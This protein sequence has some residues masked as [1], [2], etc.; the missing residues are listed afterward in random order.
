M[1]SASTGWALA[2]TNVGNGLGMLVRTTDGGGHWSS[3]GPPPSLA[4]T[5]GGADAPDGMKAWLLVAPSGYSTASHEQSVV[6]STNDGGTHWSS[7]PMFWVDGRGSGIQFLDAAHGWVFATPSAGGAIGAGDTTLYRTVD[8][9]SSWQAVKP[10]SQ[11]PGAG[12]PAIAGLPESCPMGGPID[13]PTFVDQHTGWLGAF[14]DRLFFYVSHDGGLSWTPQNL[15]PFPGPASA[16]PA[17]SLQ[18]NVDSFEVMA[19]GVYGM[20]A[21]RGMTTGG[22]ALQDAALYVTNDGGGSWAATRLPYAELVD[23]FVD[24]LHG[25]MIAAGA[26]G[27]TERRSLYL[28]VDG[29]QSWRL[30]NGPQSDLDDSLSFVDA[31]TGFMVNRSGGFFRTSDGGASWVRIS[32]AVN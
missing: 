27:D 11:V 13:R 19:P 24:P 15:P 1:V 26:G 4:G 25:W 23:D 28:T 14:C 6:A 17:N 8:G 12:R 32:T 21:H 7:T 22:N 10:P 16:V 18:Y 5:V 31:R 9:G 20:V 29:G 30:L 2:V 3:V